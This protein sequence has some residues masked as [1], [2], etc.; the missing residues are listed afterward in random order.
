MYAAVFH[1][2]KIATSVIIFRAYFATII[3][4]PYDEVV[5]AQK[6]SE[7]S[8]NIKTDFIVNLSHELRTP[9]NIILNATKLIKSRY[10][11]IKFL[12]SIENATYRLNKVCENILDFNEIENGNIETTLS[13]TDVVFLIDEI[14]EEAE[15]IVD[16]KELEILFDF[17]NA[18]IIATDS[19]KLKK[20]ILNIV[21]N[22]I[23]YAP[24]GGFVSIHLDIREKLYLNIFN[25]GPSIPQ[26]EINK[27]FN[28]FYKVKSDNLESTEGLGI[29]L[30]IASKYA[31]ALGG[32]IKALNYE[33]LTGY[34]IVIP[35]QKVDK[36]SSIINSFNVK[37][38]FSDIC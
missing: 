2:I 37:G 33:T 36:P 32:Y 16:D 11:N 14:L 8:S 34:K 24:R 28:K 29:G 31:G 22:S 23:K 3:K 1:I 18:D 7:E 30:Y 25:N 6:M 4:K 15:E 26:D 9:I 19:E 27:I 20:I 5:K 12:K 38:F 21:S 10:G 17:K 13:E 35:V